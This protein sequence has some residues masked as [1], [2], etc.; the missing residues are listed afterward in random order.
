MQSSNDSFIS[1]EP[2]VESEL[3]ELI[4]DGTVE[5]G[6]NIFGEDNKTSIHRK[7]TARVACVLS[8]VQVIALADR[9]NFSQIERQYDGSSSSGISPVGSSSAGAGSSVLNLSEPIR[10]TT[11]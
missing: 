2:L 3:E 8:E 9:L 4:S 1:G 11:T 5:F 7:V 6:I 10:L